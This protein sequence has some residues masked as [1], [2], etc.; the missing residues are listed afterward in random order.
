MDDAI[1][2][3]LELDGEKLRQLTGEDH[4][5]A[6]LTVEPDP[7]APTCRLPPMKLYYTL[8]F[9]LCLALCFAPYWSEGPMLK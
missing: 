1:L 9:L 2:K 7:T 5:P 3:A 8:L 6:F 4:G